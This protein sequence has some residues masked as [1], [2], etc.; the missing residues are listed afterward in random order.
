MVLFTNSGRK[1]INGCVDVES[2]SDL[3]CAQDHLLT[4]SR[5]PLW[6]ASRYGVNNHGIVSVGVK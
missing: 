3:N 5:H 6:V 1:F 2:L 4:A